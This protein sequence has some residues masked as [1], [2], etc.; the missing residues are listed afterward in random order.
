MIV[1]QDDILA[2]WKKQRFIVAKFDFLKDNVAP[3]VILTDIAFWAEHVEKLDK[4][5][6][7]NP[8]AYRTGGLVEFDTSEVLTLF[9]LRWS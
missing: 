2:D 9:V 8:G 4:W 1:N 6:E 5:C 7:H 3:T